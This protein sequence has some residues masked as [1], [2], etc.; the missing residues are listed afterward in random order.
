MF[1]SLCYLQVLIQYLST[2]L[3]SEAWTND[4]IIREISEFKGEIMGYAVETIKSLSLIVYPAINGCNKSRLAY[5]FGLLSDCYLQLEESKKSLPMIH[6]DQARLSNF[7]FSR[8]YKV[9]EQECRSV[10]FLKNLDFKN[11]AGL[12]GLSFECI[13]H[14]IFTHIDESSLEALAKMVE[15]LVGIYSDPVPGLISWQDVY[16]H[17]VLRMLETLES[18][19]RNELVTKNPENVQSL[20]CQLEQSFGICGKYIRLLAHSDALDIVKR[21][22]TIIVPLYGYRDT[23]PDNSTWQDCLIILLNFWMRLADEM[24]AIT[25]QES[26]G[27]NLGFS[28]DCLVSCLKVF[29]RLVVEDIISPSQGWG[30]AVSYANYGLIG[31][32]AFEIFIFCRAIVF[33]GCGFGAVAE[34]FSEAVSQSPTDLSLAGKTEIQNLPHLYLNLLEPILQDL[35]VAESP[36]HQNLYHLLSSLSKLEGDL[37]DM[38]LVRRQVW[39]RISKFSDNLQLP[40][41]VRVYALE[42]MQFL[43]G[44]NS[45]GFSAEIQS[46]LTP[47]EG[48]DE[49]HYTNEK[50]ETTA[51]EALTDHNDTSARLTSTL[52]ALK[53]SQLVATIMPTVEIT[54]DDLLNSETA[55]SCFLKLSGV[56]ET[57]SHIDALLAILGEWERLFMAK[58]DE[59]VS[60][61]ASDEGNGW[62]DDNWDEGWESFQDVEPLEEEKTGSFP[63]VHPLH[64]C[65][66]EIFKKLIMFSRFKDVLGLIDQSN[67]I[68]LN[69]EGARSLSQVLLEKDCF[70]ALKLVLLLPYEALQQQCLVF[71]EDKLKQGGFTGAIGQDNELLMLI[72]SSGIISSIILKSSYGTTF[73][74]IC[75]LV[76]SFSYKCQEAQLS[77]LMHKASEEGDDNERDLQVFRRILFPYFVS[78]LVKADQQLLAG[79]IV[80]KFM[81]TNASLSLVNIAEASLA[82]FLERQLHVLESDKLVLDEISSRQTLKN[83]VLRVRGK[84]ETLIQSALSLLS[85]NVG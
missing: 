44:T 41:S 55:A 83:N 14:E 47:W 25:S 65:W 18:K 10:S 84:L 75:Y 45:K 24:K 57:D 17:Y 56:T 62:N 31:D 68:L 8:F 2:L 38:K 40:G 85:T 69:E 73:S 72:F 34:V 22:F 28:P 26:A 54:P 74:F 82:R 27:E 37:E 61:E 53:S 9:I 7:G 81:H 12:G 39:E 16:K 6:P 15:T 13:S 21:Y 36:E 23:L 48:W 58:Q 29:M 1:V 11:I 3:V 43:T 60:A 71:V 19:A 42:L 30:T 4:D 46:N 67:A 52:V 66:M 64:V 80:T 32:S 70:M 20:I 77:R 51:N 76:G 35:V 33:S 49:V 5:I 79:L 78:E 50:S 59:K 63:S